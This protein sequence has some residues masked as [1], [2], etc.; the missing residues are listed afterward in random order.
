MHEQRSSFFGA[1]EFF[2]P[3]NLLNQA[4]KLLETRLNNKVLNKKTKYT[5]KSALQYYIVINILPPPSISEKG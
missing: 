3:L 5:P 4:V 1:A 2:W